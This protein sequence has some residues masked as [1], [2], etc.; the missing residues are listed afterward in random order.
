MDP[1][2][3]HPGTG[4][5]DTVPEAM[6]AALA[7]LAVAASGQAGPEELLKQLVDIATEHLDVDGAGVMVNDGTLLR[8]VHADH[9][10][11]T[12]VEQLQQLMQEGPCHD[13]LLFGVEVVVDDV[14]DPVQTAWPQYVTRLL[15]EGLLSVVAIPLISRDRV[16]GVLDLYR[17]RPGTWRLE[18]LHWARLLARMAVSY[19]VLAADRQQLVQAQQDLAHASTHDALTGLA[20]RTLLLDRLQHALYAARRH[21]RAVA[22]FFLDLDRFKAVNDTLGHAA[23][24]TV[25]ATV[26]T[27]VNASLRQEDTLAR[28]GGDEFVLLCEDLP[29]GGDGSEEAGELERHVRA[30]TTRLRRVLA[31]PLHV[32]GV[33]LVVSASIGVAVSSDVA[34]L[35]PADGGPRENGQVTAEE[36]L[37]AADAAMYRAKRHHRDEDPLAVRTASDGG[38]QRTR[39]PGR[40]LER[41]LARALT[42][43]QLQV[44]YQPITD[45][46]GTVHAVEALLR[47]QHP[48]HGL[49][50]AARFIELAV[51]T[52]LIVEIG[53]WVVDQ[54][55]AQMA[56]WQ[57][58]L[59][60][61][62]AGGP[63]CAYVNLSARELAD[64]GLT[65]TLADALRTH[66]LPPQRLGL[67]LVEDSFSDPDVLP[68][69]QEQHRRGHPLSVDDFGTG[70]SSLARLVELPVRMAKIDRAFTA[71]LEGDPRRR[72]LV[73]AVVT[74]AT[75]LDVQV[76]AE[77]VETAA[78]ASRV[79]QAGCHY[80]QGFHCGR[81]EPADVLTARWAS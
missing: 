28:L 21:Q 59:T 51:D 29:L 8:F 22:V 17:R 58:Q 9:A 13:A 7:E 27:R 36:L 61:A 63:E 49:L 44:H 4:R 57:R 15:E 56:R 67:E 16:W 62:R 68:G 66:D 5:A 80:L 2:T 72:A 14:R 45:P 35:D 73:D 70:Y 42:H 19:L 10:A 11:V 33:D 76:I 79:A 1:R 40:H 52:G 43:Q 26:A 64:P 31:R 41:Q 6:S 74:V 60:G 81:P 12:S 77:G 47:W 25:L 65:A 3:P 30:V 53:H 20:N 18:E 48:Q 54:T 71:G 46:A 39:R 34:G 24:D 55:C 69:L 32:A 23:G 38:D 78:Q 75:S 50:P 37:A